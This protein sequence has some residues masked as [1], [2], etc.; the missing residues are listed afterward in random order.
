MMISPSM[1]VEKL[2]DAEYTDLIAAREELLAFIR[3]YEEKE[4]AGDRSGHEWGVHPQPVVMYQMYLEYL[5]ELCRVMKEKYNTEY[6][7]QGRSLNDNAK[8]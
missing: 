3:D 6:V 8:N 1:Y 2:K 5:G 4:I 7:W